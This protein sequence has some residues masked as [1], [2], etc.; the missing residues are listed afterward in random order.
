VADGC[1]P[2]VEQRSIGRRELRGLG[3]AVELFRL[4]R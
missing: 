3:A 2:E 4:G 1:P